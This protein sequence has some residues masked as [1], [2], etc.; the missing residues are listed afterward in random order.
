MYGLFRIPILNW[1]VKA[2]FARTSVFELACK[3][4]D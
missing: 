1:E 4:Q 3:R 2:K